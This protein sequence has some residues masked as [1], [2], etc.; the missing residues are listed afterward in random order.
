M[1]HQDIKG[2]CLGTELRALQ[3]APFV[4]YGAELADSAVALGDFNGGGK[5]CLVIHVK[6]YEDV[7]F[8]HQ[9]AHFGIGPDGSLHLAAVDTAESGEV[10]H[11]GFTRF[12]S[13]CH[14][15]LIVCI[16]GFDGVGIEIEVLCPHGRCKST[17]G[18]AGSAP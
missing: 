3:V 11:D 1:V 2:L 18:L 13:C 5:G 14:T 6:A 15:F 9:L 7:V 16:D 17:D 10:Q 12:L 8:G 4:T